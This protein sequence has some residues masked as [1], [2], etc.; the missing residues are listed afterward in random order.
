MGL[1]RNTGEHRTHPDCLGGCLKAFLG[2][3]RWWCSCLAGAA[4]RARSPAAPRGAGTPAQGWPAGS[5]SG[6]HTAHDVRAPAASSCQPR[7]CLALPQPWSAEPAATPASNFP[8]DYLQRV[9]ETHQVQGAVG[10]GAR[11]ARHTRI[12]V[13]LAFMRCAAGGVCARH[14]G[15]ICTVRTVSTPAWSLPAPARPAARRLRQHRLWVRLED[16]GS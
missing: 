2:G 10:R 11:V 5:G 6:A 12:T 15:V 4:S 1:P 8:Q 14:A 13:P 9:K 16:C 3:C 7:P